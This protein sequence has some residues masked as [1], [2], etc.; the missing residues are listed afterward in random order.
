LFSPK[1]PTNSGELYPSD[2]VLFDETWSPSKSAVPVIGPDDLVC[3]TCNGL[4]CIHTP[5]STVKIANLATGECLHLKKPTKSLKDDHFLFYRF[6]FHPMTKE[7]KIIHFSHE[8]S[9]STEG[10]FNVIQVYTLGDDKWKDV[11]T[12]EALSLNSVKNSGVVIVDGTMYWL[13]EDSVSDWQHAVMS[14]DLGEGSFEQIELP[15]V[16]FEDWA[17]ANARHYWITE[18]NRKVCVAT[19]QSLSGF[20]I[21]K[22]K[23]WALNRNVDKRWSHMYSI[24]LSSLFARRL[25][26]VHGDKILIQD[27]DSNLYSYELLGKDLEIEFSKMVKV[28]D[29]SPRGKD[30]FQFQ[31]CV[32]SIVRLDLYAKAAVVVHRPKRQGGW[33]LK[34][35]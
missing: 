4:L 1:G 18:I 24:Q 14:F 19:S 28:L 13:T 11:A 29:L 12:P 9:P 21:W 33:G 20:L 25:N 34:K 27:C 32:K 31:I 23:V 15:S 8:S 3:G 10:R 35:W 16:D 2:V 30:D 26:F 17:H 22:L 6:G 5:T 7:Y